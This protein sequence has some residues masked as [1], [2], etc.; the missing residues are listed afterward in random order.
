MIGDTLV[1]GVV[2]LEVEQVAYFAAD[3]FVVTLAMGDAGLGNAAYYA[4][5]GLQRIAIDAA[6]SAGGFVNLITGQIDNVRIDLLFN[7]A[8]LSGRDLSAG[9]I[10]SEVAETFAN[11]T[12]SQIAC[13]LAQE[14]NLTPN[15]TAT[16]T[17][18][19]Q[20][21][22]L[23]H[24]RSG[25]AQHSR[26]GSAWNMLTLLAQLENFAVSVTGATLNFGPAPAGTPVL[27]TP[28]ACIALDFD[29]AT[30]IPSSTTVKSWNTRKKAVVM[31]TA[32]S[33]GGGS[34]TLIR[35]NLTSQ[36]AGNLAT[37]HL[38]VLSQHAVILKATLPGEMTMKPG[39]QI[40]LSGTNSRL[41]QSYV[42]DAIFRSIESH[43][44]FI[45]TIHARAMDAA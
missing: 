32:G 26:N 40:L 37:N 15:V 10:D 6:L 35:P 22:E 27:I 20:Y 44:G 31:Q 34:T 8:V 41:D 12:S 2:S 18:V 39:M 13:A 3:R 16:T 11:Q 9:L 24:A 4:A 29:I 17:P 23:D 45:E 30:T 43:H 5:L 1:F 14:H 28:Q 38:A 25:L 19:G 36:Q 21:Y 7:T 42:V 33:S